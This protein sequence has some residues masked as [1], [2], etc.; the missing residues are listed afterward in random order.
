MRT[1]ICIFALAC[2]SAAGLCGQSS[3]VGASPDTVKTK[4]SEKA[5][6]QKPPKPPKKPGKSTAA[7]IGGGAGTAA[8]GVAKGAGSAA[9]GVGKGAVDLATLH[10][11]DA[12]AAVGTGAVKGVKDVAVCSVKGAGKV[13]KG[14]CHALHKIL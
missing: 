2:A 5:K 11:I 6:K 4:N 13:V 10:P 9:S 1:T 3:G 14:V 8:T 12:G 7:D